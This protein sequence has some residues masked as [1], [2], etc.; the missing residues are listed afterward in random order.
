MIYLNV[1]YNGHIPYFLIKN[2]I[3]WVNDPHFSSIRFLS[4]TID[5]FD[6]TLHN[7]PSSVGFIS[8]SLNDLVRFVLM[9]R[10]YVRKKEKI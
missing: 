5:H 4:R 1:K 10:I 7:H 6:M 3:E 8:M 9:E 2:P